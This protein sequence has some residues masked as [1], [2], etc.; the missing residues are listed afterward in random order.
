MTTSPGFDPAPDSTAVPPSVADAVADPR[1]GAARVH[2]RDPRSGETLFTRDGEVPSPTASVM[3][4]ITCANALSVLGPEHRIETRALFGSEAG[5]IVVVGG[6]DTTLSVVPSGGAT[7]YPGVTHL[8][9]LADAI[10][11][12]RAADPRTANHP[13]TRIVL[14]ATLFERGEW[15]HTWDPAGRSPENYIPFI[16]A[17]QLDGDRIHPTEDDSPRTEDPVGR[18]GTELAAL[19][20][21]PDRDPSTIE[22]RRGAAPA[23]AAP[24]A[25][26]LSPP[27]A[28]LVTFS[29]WT[30]DNALTESLAR[31]VAL[32]EGDEPDFGGI[33]RTAPAV[34]AR[35][36]VDP[37]GCLLTDGSGLSDDNRA[38]AAVIT[39][40][41]GVA[42]RREHG[43]G[44]LDDRMTRSGPGGTLAQGRFSGESAVVGG[45][46]RAKTGYINAVH[47]LA[48]IVTTRQGTDLAFAVFATGELM[49]PPNRLAV[50]AA[51]AALWQH[52]LG[53]AS[54]SP[55]A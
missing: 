15:H 54:A 21:G 47:S 20:A 25:S 52:G 17:L 9:E 13:V 39:Q 41:L 49:G 12:A 50:D 29:L 5:E 14:D 11:A 19:L 33:S 22:L 4:L 1:L 18:F 35:L 30:S 46:V 23:D 28:E 8:D 51:V 55:S 3:K 10:L 37:S 53:D 38:P 43:L 16:T 34:L 7:L 32:A 42:F 36:G 48:G 2:I 40:L 26:V 44:E 31:L 24:L 6:G 45:A 27:L